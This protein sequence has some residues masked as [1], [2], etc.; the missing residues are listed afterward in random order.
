MRRS[1]KIASIS[2]NFGYSDNAIGIGIQFYYYGFAPVIT[3]SLVMG[4]HHHVADRCFF[5][6]FPPLL[7]LYQ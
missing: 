4:D 7:P 1:N 6:V 2:A 3:G 5:T